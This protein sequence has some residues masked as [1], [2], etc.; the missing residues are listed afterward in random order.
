MGFLEGLQG[1]L[2]VF[3]QIGEMFFSGQRSING[4]HLQMRGDARALPSPIPEG[5]ASLGS[6]AEGS[7]G[8]EEATVPMIEAPPHIPRPLSQAQLQAVRN[9]MHTLFILLH[10]LP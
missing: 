6:Q 9:F 7:N 1:H 8:F 10:M 3:T 2:A 4:V 5:S